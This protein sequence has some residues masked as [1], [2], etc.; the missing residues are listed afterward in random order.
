M[1]PLPAGDYSANAPTSR[2]RAGPDN[3]RRRRWAATS[4][5]GKPGWSGGRHDRSGCRKPAPGCHSPARPPW[6]NQT[7]SES[8]VWSGRE[9]SC[10]VVL[11]KGVRRCRV[12]HLHTPGWSGL[13]VDLFQ[14]SARFFGSFANVFD[15]KSHGFKRVAGFADLADNHLVRPIAALDNPLLA[16]RGIAADEVDDA[17]ILIPVLLHRHLQRVRPIL[18]GGL[19]LEL[20]TGRVLLGA[21]GRASHQKAPFLRPLA[22]RA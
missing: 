17:S 20:V 7:A 15:L 12:R 11:I 13:L 21:I 3:R 19:D 14:V 9:G 22:E 16:E 8:G 1:K 2:H 18:V 10:P 5:A 6:A 4:A